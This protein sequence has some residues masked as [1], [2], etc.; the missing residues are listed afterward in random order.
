MTKSELLSKLKSILIAKDFNI[1]QND[2]ALLDYEIDRAIAEINKCRRFTPT[3][4]KLYDKKY[5]SLI[6]P[7][8]VSAFAK[9]GAE[10]QT[11]HTENGI[12]RNYTSGGDYP[13]D[14]LNSIIPLIK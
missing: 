7:L 2:S 4:T 10:G 13:K 9:A 1:T 14:I 11:S 3:E 8:C 5:E 12:V 6:I